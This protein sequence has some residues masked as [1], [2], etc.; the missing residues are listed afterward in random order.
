MLAESTG[1]TGALS[2][3]MARRSSIPSVHDRGRVLTDVAVLLTDRG[4]AI[5]QIPMRYRRN[6]LIRCDGAGASHQ[7]LAWLTAQ[8]QVRGRM[9]H[10]SVRFTIGE[11]VRN[12]IT[13]LLAGL[14]SPALKADGEV[15]DGGE[16]AEVTGP[17]KF[18]GWPAVMRVILRRERPHP[19]LNSRCP[20]TTTAGGLKR[21]PP[22]PAAALYSSS[23]PGIG[24]TGSRFW[25]CRGSSL[26]PHH[27][28]HRNTLSTRPASWPA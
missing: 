18:D 13:E 20:K 17:L 23:R 5:A 19:G 27:A 24:R 12:A 2:T 6:L 15:R 16:V 1:L 3:A 26:A 14:W 22:T 9:L 10:Y 11:N 21:S 4:E 7:L 8:G 28:R 25:V